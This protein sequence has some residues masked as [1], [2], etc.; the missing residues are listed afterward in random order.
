MYYIYQYVCIVECLFD[1]YV[2]V[3][4]P[5]VRGGVGCVGVCCAV[6]GDRLWL[7]LVI[8]MAVAGVL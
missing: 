2:E 5:V 1:T 7:A 4:C 3:P 6:A 8:W